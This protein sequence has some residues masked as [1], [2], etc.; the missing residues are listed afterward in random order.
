MNKRVCKVDWAK[1]K[2]EDEEQEEFDTSGMGECALLNINYEL[3][4]GSRSTFY[5]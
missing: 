3:F 4:V 5:L 2:D 1:W